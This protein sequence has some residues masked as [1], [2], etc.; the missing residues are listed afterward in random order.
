MPDLKEKL[1]ELVGQVQDCGCDVT[2]VVEMNYVENI[3]LVDHLIANGV[4]IQEWYSANDYP[5]EDGTY[6]VQTT[7]GTITTAKFYA[8]KSFPA[9]RHLPACHRPASWQSNRN[10]VKWTYLPKPQKGE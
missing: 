7:T 9:T 2:D 3:T 8:F 6:I 5:K 10:V 4:T 1:V